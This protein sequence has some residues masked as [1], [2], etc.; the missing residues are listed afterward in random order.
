MIKALSDTLMD[1]VQ[2]LEPFFVILLDTDSHTGQSFDDIAQHVQQVHV[3]HR[4]NCVVAALRRLL[5]LLL[6]AR[7]RVLDGSTHR[8]HLA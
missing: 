6:L 2:Q 1:L 4:E 8:P 7:V 3:V 5:L